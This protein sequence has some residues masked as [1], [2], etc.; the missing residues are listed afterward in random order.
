[1]KLRRR[2]LK[3]NE[4][5]T[6][7]KIKS[8]ENHILSGRTSPLRPHNGVRIPPPPEKYKLQTTSML[9]VTKSA[10]ATKSARATLKL[11]NQLEQ[12]YQL[13]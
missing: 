1:M 12:P 4:I 13:S 8:S 7:F 11:Q 5:D 9:Q 10:K 6:L 3:I 2:R